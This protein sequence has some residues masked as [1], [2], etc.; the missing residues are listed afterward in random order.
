MS[1]VWTI[2]ERLQ[3]Q[4]S[5]L[6]SLSLFSLFS[7]VRLSIQLKSEV[8]LAQ[9]SHYSPTQPPLFLPPTVI[10]FLSECCAIDKRD[11]PVLWDELKETIWGA[12]PTINMDTDTMYEKHGLKLGFRE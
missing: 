6:P 11:V 5:P 10:T 1:N 2:L 9:P 12:D 7:F 8:I 4:L 3:Q